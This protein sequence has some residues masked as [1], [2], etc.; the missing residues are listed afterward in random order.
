MKP[1]IRK[2]M[3]RASW[4]HVAPIDWRSTIP[5]IDKE[6]DP[7]RIV[8]SILEETLGQP[9][10]ARFTSDDWDKENHK[11]GLIKW[12]LDAHPDSYYQDLFDNA[13]SW[14]V[15]LE[16]LVKDMIG[17]HCIPLIDNKISVKHSPHVPQIAAKFREMAQWIDAAMATP[18]QEQQLADYEEKNK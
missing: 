9:A 16:T 7:R 1:K 6:D 2:T 12:S 10:W 11:V 4:K 14:E 17:D 18:E 5:P 8:A 15:D 3:C 13:P